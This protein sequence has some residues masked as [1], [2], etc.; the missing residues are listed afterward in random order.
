ML[1]SVE[2]DPLPAEPD[3]EFADPEPE[4]DEELPEEEPD[5]LVFEESEPE[6]EPE[7]LLPEPLPEEEPLL[8]EPEFPELE[9]LPALLESEEPDELLPDVLPELDELSCVLVVADSLVDAFSFEV[10]SAVEACLVCAVSVAVN[11]GSVFSPIPWPAVNTWIRPAETAM[12]I[13]A[14]TME[15]MITLRCTRALR[16]RRTCARCTAGSTALL[17][18]VRAW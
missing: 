15:T 16:W 8:E 18:E 11:I 14:E 7:L 4:P 5:P 2:A 13:N 6:D 9:L 12:A 3:S 1:D 10:F 17:V